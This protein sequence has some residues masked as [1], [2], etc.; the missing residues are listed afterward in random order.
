MSKT[1]PS[2][3]DL[4]PDIA[5]TDD[6]KNRCL[7]Y[8][9]GE[10]DSEQ[11]EFFEDELAESRSLGN[12]LHRQAET[13]SM[14]SELHTSEEISASVQT[15]SRLEAGSLWRIACIAIAVCF[16]GMVVRTWWQTRDSGSQL[17]VVQPDTSPRA[18]ADNRTDLQLASVPEFTLIARAWADSQMLE[19]SG[20]RKN[21]TMPDAT[22]DDDTFGDYLKETDN[23]V[24][25]TSS[26]QR[27]S[28]I[29]TAVTEI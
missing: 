10:L 22:S 24:D 23:Q 26:E 2:N 28:W 14:L 17:K 9:L 3:D 4:N 21:S 15:V 25:D 18:V 13:I 8:L 20:S 7:Q 1:V 19:E 16:A 27:F 12:E 11:V 29:F 6:S 5:L